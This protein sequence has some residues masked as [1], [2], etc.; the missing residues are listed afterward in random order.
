[1]T[2]P[3]CILA[4]CGFSMTT[5]WPRLAALR[6]TRI[7]RGRLSP[8]SSTAPWNIATIWA[9]L[10]WS[11]PAKS[12]AGTGVVHSESKPSKRDPVHLLQL[13]IMPAVK[14][15]PPSWEPKSFSWDERSGQCLPIA[16]PAGSHGSS[17]GDSGKRAVQIHQDAKIFTSLAGPRPIRH[18][19]DRRRTARLYFRDRRETHTQRRNARTR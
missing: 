8:I 3:T 4:R 10:E 7:L 17:G 19:P 1:M 2:R 11:A 15:L 6:S 16:V 13:W 12:S 9:T 14:H 18:A 5:L